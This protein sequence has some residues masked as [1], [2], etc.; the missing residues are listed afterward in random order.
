MDD[1]KTHELD[2]IINFVENEQ[3]LKEYLT[4]T[5]SESVNIDF[6]NY[7]EKL[8]EKKNLSKANLIKAAGLDR[9]YGYQILSGKKNASRDKILRLCIAGNL[10][11]EETNRL[12]S[13]GSYP[14]L[15]SKDR[16][17]SIITFALNKCMSTIDVDLLLDKYNQIPLD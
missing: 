2:N 9:N 7:L 10:T 8:I 14:R 4:K 3:Q 15:Y 5:I 17:D 12:L 13:L 1:K 11:L 16:R 6:T